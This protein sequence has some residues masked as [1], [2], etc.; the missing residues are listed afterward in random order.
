MEKSTR[1]ILLSTVLLWLLPEVAYAAE[2]AG[3][4]PPGW[5]GGFLAALAFVLAVA[6]GISWFRH[7]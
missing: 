7:S 2:G 6:L 3:V 1:L 5:V 4:N